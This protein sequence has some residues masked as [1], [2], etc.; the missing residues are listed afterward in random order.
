MR[1]KFDKIDGFIR[2]LDSEIKHL[3]LFDYGLFDK[4]CDRIK[5]LLSE[6]SGVTI[7]F[8]RNFRKIRSYSYN[9]L[10]IEK[11]LTFQVIIL[12]HVII[13]TYQGSHKE[14]FNTK[15]F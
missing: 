3:V 13:L 7:S 2:V 4:I 9:S 6:R 15:Y 11:V 5:Y 12:I 1:I 10:P 8:N 14:K